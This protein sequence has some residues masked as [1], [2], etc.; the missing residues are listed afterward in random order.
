MSFAPRRT[1]A[2][3]LACA[4]AV[5]SL[6]LAASAH[7]ATAPASLCPADPPVALD[8]SFSFSNQVGSAACVTIH[9]SA[10]GQATI[11]KIAVQPGWT[12]SVK[13]AG[14]TSSR[15]RIEVLFNNAATRAKAE[16]R[17][18]PGKLVIK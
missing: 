5:A 11:Q 12:S 6:G 9:V 14:G 7:A 8:G 3:A 10:L 1:G 15:N 16:F 4:V 2:R 13:S 17:S 18:E